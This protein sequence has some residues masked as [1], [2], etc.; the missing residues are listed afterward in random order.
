MMNM[1]AKKVLIN[2]L[3]QK[4]KSQIK[5]S[6]QTYCKSKSLVICIVIFSNLCEENILLLGRY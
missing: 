6:G 1:S 5:S 3:K 2:Y 4:G